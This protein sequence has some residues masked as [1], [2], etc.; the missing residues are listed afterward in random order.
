MRLLFV[1]LKHIG[2]ALLLTP[3]LQAVRESHP[4]AVI[5][6]VVRR[7]TEGV[8]SGCPAIDRVITAAAP[9]LGRRSLTG[10]WSE[11]R[12]GLELRR[13]RFDYAFE[14]TDGDRGRWFAGLSAASKRCAN[15]SLYPLNLWWRLWFNRASRHNWAQGH[16]VEKDFF[17]VSDF[18]P[19]G[20]TPP[21][22]VFD[23]SRTRKWDQLE[24]NAP[25]ALL[26]PGTR[27]KRKRWLHPRW[28]EVGRFLLDRVP[29]IVISSGPDAEEVESAARLAA[30]LGPRAISTSGVLTWSQMAWMLHRAKLFVGVD[31]AAM[32]LAAACQC[33]IVALFGPSIVSQWAPWKVPHKIV[34]PTS[35]SWDGT[36]GGDFLMETIDSQC[37]IEACKEM[38][39]YEKPTQVN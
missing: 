4:D 34:L 39:R 7:G 13:Q 16:R 37:V 28:V 11:V 26:H 35:G 5:W 1:K 32:H 15:T 25:F 30:D 10:F 12:S 2:D 20:V 23:H 38:L 8:L 19:I 17:T 36:G 3:T 21:P 22:L 29:R 9:E 24:G 18:L 27:W 6:V 31:T 33:P 14:L